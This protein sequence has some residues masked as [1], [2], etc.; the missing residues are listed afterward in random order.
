MVVIP[1][2][3]GDEKVVRVV[4]GDVVLSP[5]Q[6][7]KASFGVPLPPGYTTTFAWQL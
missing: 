5:R 7:L 1:F 4:V 3:T 2:K 6:G